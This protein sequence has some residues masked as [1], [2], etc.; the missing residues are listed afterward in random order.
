[1]GVGGTVVFRGSEILPLTLPVPLRRLIGSSAKGHYLLNYSVYVR[2]F[3]ELSVG[4][5][6]T[7]PPVLPI[8]FFPFVPGRQG[9]FYAPFLGEDATA[10]S[11]ADRA[12]SPRC[13]RTPRVVLARLLMMVC[14]LGVE[15]ISVVGLRVF[16]HRPDFVGRHG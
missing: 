1:M 9:V 8:V 4:T 15:W 10:Q 6:V 11:G 3:V 14:F 13:E 12:G 16:I 2:V 5:Y 7:R